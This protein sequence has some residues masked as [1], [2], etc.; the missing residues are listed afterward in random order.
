MRELRIEYEKETVENF[1]E[2]ETLCT[3]SKMYA[4]IFKML[5]KVQKAKQLA[6]IQTLDLQLTM[7]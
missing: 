1:N 3:G 5:K 6:Q 7:Q 4:T 2:E